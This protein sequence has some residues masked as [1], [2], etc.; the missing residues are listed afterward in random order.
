MMGISGADID[1]A[2]G[3]FGG[4]LIMSREFEIPFVVNV[5]GAIEAPSVFIVAWGM[6]FFTGVRRSRYWVMA[7][8][9]IHGFLLLIRIRLA[10]STDEKF[11]RV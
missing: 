11:G 9:T 1:Y 7:E 4:F 5:K 10:S 8:F 6:E 3:G 2:I